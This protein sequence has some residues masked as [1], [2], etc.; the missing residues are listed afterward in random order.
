MRTRVYHVSPA[1]DHRR[2]VPYQERGTDAANDAQHRAAAAEAGYNLFLVHADDVFIDLLTDSGT[3]AMS[4]LQWSG[5]LQ[6]DES[7]AGSR[8]F[9]RLE[10]AVRDIT[11]YR[12]VIPT[13]QGR[14]AER[15]LFGSV[16]KPATSYQ[17]TPTSTPPAPTSRRPVPWLATL[18]FPKVSAPST[19]PLQGKHGCGTS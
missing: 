8:S 2:A 13:H 6:G 5:M 1:E 18:S 9:Y 17:T 16:C 7:Y 10:K 19:A 3:G 14:A 4:T 12:H 11:G 15:I